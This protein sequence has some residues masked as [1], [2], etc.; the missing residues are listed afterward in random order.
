MIMPSV[1]E[2]LRYLA[3]LSSVNSKGTNDSSKIQVR[4][5]IS[6]NFCQL[7]LKTS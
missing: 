6:K 5:N 1:P 3:S 7:F 4:G 2:I